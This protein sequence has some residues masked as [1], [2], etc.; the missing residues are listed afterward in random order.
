MEL[1]AYLG[2]AL[3][4]VP[5]LSQREVLRIIKVVGRHRKEIKNIE[6]T[7][8]NNKNGWVTSG[9]A[10]KE[11]KTD[12]RTTNEGGTQHKVDL[13]FAAIMLPTRMTVI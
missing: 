4:F 8:E 2:D 7:L 9:G 12:G 13:H 3:D 11:R 10:V 6:K 1:L 5:K